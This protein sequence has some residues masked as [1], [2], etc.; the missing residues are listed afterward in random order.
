MNFWTLQSKIDF[1]TAVSQLF[2]LTD[3]PCSEQ[4]YREYNQL[5]EEKKDEHTL[6]FA[7]ELQISD[8]VAFL[9]QCEESVKTVSADTLC[10]DQDGLSILIASNHTPSQTILEGVREIIG[11]TSQY[12]LKSTR[13]SFS[14]KC[15]E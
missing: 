6:S 1:H 2:E 4:I 7:D 10:E 12:T 14:T 8:N 5:T 13:E 11:V 15:E 9:A 3:T